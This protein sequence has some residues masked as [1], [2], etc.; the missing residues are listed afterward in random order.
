MKTEVRYS[1]GKGLSRNGAGER[2]EK[3]W[4]VLIETVDMF[5]KDYG[6]VLL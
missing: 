5:L 4:W 2:V 1:E 3:E 6:N